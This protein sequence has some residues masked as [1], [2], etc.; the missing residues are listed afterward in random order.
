MIDQGFTLDDLTVE[1]NHIAR[2]HNDA[3][4]RLNVADW[5][6]HLG[7]VRLEPDL[8]DIERHG[9]REVGNRLFV[10]PLLEDLAEAQHEHDGACRIEIAAH[11]RNSD[12]SGVKH[13]NGEMTVQQRLNAL[14]DVLCGANDG[15][16]HANGRREEHFGHGAAQHRKDELV[17]KLAVQCAGGVIRHKLHAFGFRERECRERTNKGCAVVLIDDNGVLCA[18]VN[19]NFLY[20][21]HGAQVI[22]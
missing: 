20:A 9:A 17:F 16:H 1:R 13:S 10:R 18:V 3:V 22:L 14:F 19:L 5:H 2:A 12:S 6:E 11:K 21:V 7:A 8:I 4:A 15:K